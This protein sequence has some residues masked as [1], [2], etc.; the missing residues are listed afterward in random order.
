MSYPG[1]FLDEQALR[2]A[3]AAPL[4]PGDMFYL[5]GDRDVVAVRT[6][7]TRHVLKGAELEAVRRWVI[8]K[9]KR[10]AQ[11]NPSHGGGRSR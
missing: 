3:Q 5:V 11:P 8:E 4:L 6:D 10:A 1:Q 7:G 2:E 9:A